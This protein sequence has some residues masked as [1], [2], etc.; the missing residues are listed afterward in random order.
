M[1]GPN[2][3]TIDSNVNDISI[4]VT[5][6]LVKV[7]DENC[8]TEISITQPVT[9]V[10]QVA[11]PGPIGP[12]GPRGIDGRTT[13]FLATGSVTASVDVTGDIFTVTSASADIF[14]VN[15]QGVITL[16]EQ[17]ITPTAIRGGI[18]FSGSGDFFV[19]S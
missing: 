14:S 8:P 11:A 3:I 15:Y 9:R 18:F 16:Q 4:D 12:R 10:V 5:E 7:I 2:Q 1:A 6:N 13:N 17:L 19:G